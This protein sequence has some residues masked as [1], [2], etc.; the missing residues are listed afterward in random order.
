MDFAKKK[1]GKDEWFTPKEAIY[2]ILRHLKHNSIVWCPFDT[3][4]SLFGE[5]HYKCFCECLTDMG[6]SLSLTDCRSCVPELFDGV[7]I[8]KNQTIFGFYLEK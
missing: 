2:P 3:E 6:R 5:E 1:A 7:P 4:D 8:K